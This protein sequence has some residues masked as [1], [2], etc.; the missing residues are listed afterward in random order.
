MKRLHLLVH[1]VLLPEGEDPDSFARKSSTD[2]VASYLRD[3]AV[4]LERFYLETLLKDF[5]AGAPGPLSP[6]LLGKVSERYAKICARLKNPVERGL[7]QQ[8]AQALGI[9]CETL[10]LTQAEDVAMARLET[11]Q[12]TAI[13]AESCAQV[14][15]L[16]RDQLRVEGAE[17]AGAAAADHE[18]VNQV[19]PCESQDQ[20]NVPAIAESYDG[21]LPYV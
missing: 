13:F 9:A 3:S 19:R 7:V 11:F 6:T 2:A 17:V 16:A 20:R 10:D 4:P 18:L 21:R 5:A 12:P 1:V 14:V 15:L 8:A